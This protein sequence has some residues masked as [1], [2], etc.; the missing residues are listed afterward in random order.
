MFIDRLNEA[1]KNKKMTGNKLCSIMGINNA[2]YTS[3]KKMKPKAD[4]LKEI[5]DILEVSVDWLLEREKAM[6]PRETKLLNNYREADER[7]KRRIDNL[8]EEEAQEQ[9]SLTSG[10]GYIEKNEA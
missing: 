1:L 6:N 8:A 9:Q 2:S 7:G 5:A 4:T 3:W 10:N